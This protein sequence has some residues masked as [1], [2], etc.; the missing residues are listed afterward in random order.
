MYSSR[1]E[2]V[3]A[4]TQR[5]RNVFGLSAGA[6]SGGAAVGP[7][8][9]TTRPS[10]V[11]AILPSET[12]NADALLDAPAHMM[13]PATLIAERYLHLTLMNALGPAPELVEAESHQRSKS[14]SSGFGAGASEDNQAMD[15]ETPA[16]GGASYVPTAE[17]MAYL[18][19]TFRLGQVI[20]A[21][22]VPWVAEAEALLAAAPHETE[23]DSEM[24]VEVEAGSGE[25]ADEGEDA[26]ADKKEEVEVEDDDVPM[27]PVEAAATPKSARK[28][29]PASSK[30]AANGSVSKG[31]TGT[32]L[33]ASHRAKKNAAGSAAATPNGSRS[34]NN[35]HSKQ[36][37]PKTPAGTVRG[38]AAK[39]N[40]TVKLAGVHGKSK[41]ASSFSPVSVANGRKSH[42][43]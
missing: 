9:T 17:S 29:S 16:A 14:S 36:A 10:G 39:P 11:A 38:S 32:P 37:S 20:S 3:D 33:V 22:M 35:G 43:E 12:A 8:S 15:V 34:S 2:E 40:T 13:A 23:A 6:T 21:P 4:M 31:K 28:K 18:K 5:F 24:K 30:Q 42:S 26:G 25:D 27:Q 19:D 1:I 7:G 41:L